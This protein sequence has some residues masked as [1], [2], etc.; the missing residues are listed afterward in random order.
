M[1]FINAHPDFKS[2]FILYLQSK[3]INVMEHILDEYSKQPLSKELYESIKWWE[4]RRAF[5]NLCVGVSGIIPITIFWQSILEIGYFF[6][7]WEGEN[8]SV[9]RWKNS[10]PKTLKPSIRYKSIGML[11]QSCRLATLR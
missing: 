5:Y 9:G 7:Q 3:N 2:L 8:P 1:L 11:K 10:E 4:K 6:R